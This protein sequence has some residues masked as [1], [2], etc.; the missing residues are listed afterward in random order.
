MQD[1]M[2]EAQQE[3]KQVPFEEQLEEALTINTRE[4]FEGVL[5]KANE[6]II[7]Q[8]KQ[9]T[10]L[11]EQQITFR[12]EVAL[13]CYVPLI[14]KVNDYPKAAQDAFRAADA[15]LRFREQGNG[16]EHTFEQK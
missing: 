15:F 9:I 2:T 14:E 8:G 16:L 11:N 13:Q 5:K 10:L 1:E 6:T 3:P 7:G 12:D 4:F